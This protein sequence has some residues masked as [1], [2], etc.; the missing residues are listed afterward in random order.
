MDDS[1][2]LLEDGRGIVGTEDCRVVVVEDCRT[3]GSHMEL[4][5]MTIVD[6][7]R[8]YDSLKLH[9]LPSLNSQIVEQT[10]Q[11]YHTVKADLCKMANH[12]DAYNHKRVRF[13]IVDNNN[14][15][16]KQ[17]HNDTTTRANACGIIV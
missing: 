16:N 8:M 13:E 15:N 11:I 2:I 14:D 9:S 7:R 3:G 17:Q 10:A 12:V 1:R 6:V 5:W 4:F